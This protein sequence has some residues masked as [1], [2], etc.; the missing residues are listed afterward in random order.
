[1]TDDAEKLNQAVKD[2]LTRCYAA[3]NHLAALT[4]FLTELRQKPEWSRQ[5]IAHVHTAVLR[6]LREI[7]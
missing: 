6:I 2:C 1:M 4:E 5:E 7:S 3:E